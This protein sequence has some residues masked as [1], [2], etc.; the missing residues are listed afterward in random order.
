M[1]VRVASFNVENLFA[2]PKVF[3]LPMWAQGQPILDAFAEFNSLIERPRYSQA[4]KSRMIDLLVQLD[5]YS[6]NT[7][8]VVHRNRVPDPKWAWLR[9]NRGTFDIDHKDTGIE[10]V[11][12]GRDA[13]TGWAELAKAPTNEVATRM[14]A[15]V[16]AQVDADVLCV[17]EAED[18]PSVD[19]FNQEMLAGRYAHAML[20]DG[21]DPRGIDV[22]LLTKAGFDIVAMRSNVDVPDPKTPNEHLFSR[23][24]AMYQVSAP[25]GAVWVL[26]NH[27]KSKSG[28]SNTGA[29]RKRQADGVR[30]VVDRLLADGETRIIVLGDLNEG[31][32]KLGQDPPDL[33]ALYDPAGPL[34]SVFDLPGFDPGPRPG[35]FGSCRID[36]RF[37]HILLSTALV[38]QL[39]AGGIERHGLW[40]TPTNKH[41]PTM[42]DAFPEIQKPEQAASDHAAIYIDLN[43]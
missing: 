26:L 27:F 35:T 29:K 32:A 13:W 22:G 33:T 3:S 42:W 12:T 9:A 4:D 7:A 8:G 2:R 41:R 36:E 21:N 1:G 20:I 28:T 24:C 11:A 17:V 23:D 25:G 38:P 39:V 37:D 30:S 10:I 14:T 16:I 19:R 15:K 5:I 31:P 43:H 40:G 6:K 18:R 34:R